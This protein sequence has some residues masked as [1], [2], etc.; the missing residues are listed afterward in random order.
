MDETI[1]GGGEKEK[2]DVDCFEDALDQLPIH[3][4]DQSLSLMKGGKEKNEKQLK[5]WIDEASSSNISKS[6][7]V[8]NS[9]NNEN[10]VW[11]DDIVG[12]VGSK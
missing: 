10:L 8:I 12:L 4:D 3:I 7:I 9:D 5:D 11:L 2:E 1:D 6:D